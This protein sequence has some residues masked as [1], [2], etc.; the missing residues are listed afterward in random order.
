MAKTT[1][2]E[3]EAVLESLV[4]WGLEDDSDDVAKNVLSNVTHGATS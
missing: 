4:A 3:Y 1:N 2:V